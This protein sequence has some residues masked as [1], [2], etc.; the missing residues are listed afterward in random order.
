MPTVLSRCTTTSVR[1]RFGMIF[2]L[3]FVS[4]TSWVEAGFYGAVYTSKT[5][6][7][8]QNQSLKD[9][10]GNGGKCQNLFPKPKVGGSS[11][12]G[13]A[14]TSRSVPDTWVTVSSDHMGNTLGHVLSGVAAAKP[15][16]RY[17]AM[18]ARF[19]SGFAVWG[20]SEPGGGRS[21]RGPNGFSR[22]SSL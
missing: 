7:I 11:P 18:G 5:K 21:S 19:G 1:C 20:V 13:T 16:A 6:I 17:G 12:P 3:H 2:C 22:G 8:F 9:T 15:L 14:K 4:Q 10:T